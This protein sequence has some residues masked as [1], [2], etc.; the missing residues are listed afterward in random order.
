[1]V[2]NSD[3]KV[4]IQTNVK[5]DLHNNIWWLYD[6][7]ISVS[8]YTCS[9]QIHR[10]ISVN[11]QSAIARSTALST[12]GYIPPPVSFNNCL[13]VILVNSQ[14]SV[15]PSWP[16]YLHTFNKYL[17]WIFFPQPAHSCGPPIL[18][19]SSFTAMIIVSMVVWSL[20]VVLMAVAGE[21]HW[22]FSDKLNLLAS[23]REREREREGGDGLCLSRETARWRRS[24]GRDRLTQTSPLICQMEMS[25][26]CILAV[27][28]E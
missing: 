3:S 22:K 4:Q 13:N 25:K 28:G 19:Q 7:Q 15:S 1:M 14:H 27:L 9:V 11:L 5:L 24:L 26:L 2:Y 12:P 21:E 17:S 8:V 16:L 18:P 10:Y 6:S 20:S 23:E